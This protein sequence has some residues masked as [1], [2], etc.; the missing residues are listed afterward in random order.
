MSDI[1]SIR[2]AF[3]ILKT[4]GTNADGATLTEISTQ[5][6][7]PKSTVSRMLSTLAQVGAIEKLGGRDG[8]RLGNELLALASNTPYPRNLAAIAR[9]H[10]QQ[11][12]QATGET[13]T[14]CVPEGDHAHYIDQI[15][16]SR[17]IVMTD[18]RRQKLPL[19]TT[20]DGKLFLSRWAEEGLSR[21]LAQPLRKYTRTTLVTANALKRELKVIA[22]RGYAWTDGEYDD[23]I[24]GIAAPILDS[25]DTVVASV[26]VF[27]PRYRFPDEARASSLISQTTRAAKAITERLKGVRFTKP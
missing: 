13:L 2:R 26:C 11:L 7:L 24:I 3:D 10:L 5:L 22:K 21:Y 15:N 18:W 12:A 16:S 9:P 6:H 25:A 8:F 19:H 14:L 23:D 1:Q 27:G 17:N 20:S 4:V